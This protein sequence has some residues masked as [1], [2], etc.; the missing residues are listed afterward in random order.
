[1]GPA[2]PVRPVYSVLGSASLGHWQNSH[3]GQKS[4]AGN[5]CGSSAGNLLV[6]GQQKFVGKQSLAL[7]PKLECSNMILAHCILCLPGSRTTGVHDHAQLIF[8]FLVE[9][10]FHHV[11]QAGLK[12]LTSGDSP[13]SASQS[14]G[15]TGVNQR[16]QPKTK[17]FFETGSHAV[18]QA[19]VQWCHVGSLQPPPLD[20]KQFS[21]LSLQKMGFYHVGQP[22]LKLLTSSDPPTSA[23]HSAGIT[24][25]SHRTRLLM[26][27]LTRNTQY[28]IQDTSLVY[29]ALQMLM[30]GSQVGMHGQKNELG[31]YKNSDKEGLDF[32]SGRDWEIPGR[33]ATRVAGATLLA[34]AALL[35]APST[36]LPGAECAGLTGSA[37]PI[38]TRKTAIG[39]AED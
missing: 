15:V 18:I 24:G 11:G 13:A 9:I 26:E 23:S 28:K 33:E 3:A 27:N 8:A 32:S 34:G 17:I 20:F 2:E 37:G 39:S 10:G 31:D 35:L 21:P 19:G 12:L 14:A 16:S 7:P 30:F 36:A 25:V 38:P 22:G 1:M 29:P 5:P 4:R 6:C